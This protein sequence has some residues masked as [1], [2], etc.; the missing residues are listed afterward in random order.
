VIERLKKDP[1][2]RALR[3]DKL[4]LAALEATLALYAEPERAA[5]EIP[6]L[7]MLR[8][9]PETLAPRAR[10][11]AEALEARIPRLRAR[12]VRGDGEVGGG[13]LPLQKLPGWVVEVE[14]PE[15]PANGLELL[16]H[17][18]N[19][20]VIGTIRSGRFRLDPRTLDDS[21]IEEAA[22]SLARV[23]SGPRAVDPGADPARDIER[24]A[25]HP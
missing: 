13:S 7:A 24:G 15:R 22:N 18:A 10:R 5:R 11:L 2:A 19:P 16:A 3:V 21:E 23:W 14:M 17:A 6:A 20:P 9:S 1:L 4:S 12:V 8:A 25:P